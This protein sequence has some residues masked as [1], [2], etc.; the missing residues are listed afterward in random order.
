MFRGFIITAIVFLGMHAGPAQAQ[1]PGGSGKVEIDLNKLPPDLVKQIL[2]AQKKSQKESKKDQKTKKQPPKG[3]A[4]AISLSEA[5]AAAEKASK[6]KATSASR[7]DGPD[8]TNFTVQ[9]LTPAGDRVRYTLSATG[10]VLEQRKG[11]DSD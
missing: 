3:A 5:V 2:D 4:N 7:K 8:Y 9:I 6:G 11:G 1:Q 10:A